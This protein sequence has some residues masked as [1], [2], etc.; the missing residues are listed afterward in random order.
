M[1]AA[2]TVLREL[3]LKSPFVLSK[4]VIIHK[5]IELNGSQW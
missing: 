2:Y 5:C 4:V 3:G 1:I